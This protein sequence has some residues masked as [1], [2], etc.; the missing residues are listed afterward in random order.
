MFSRT[1]IPETTESFKTAG[2]DSGDTIRINNVEI[3]PQK[4]LSFQA[5]SGNRCGHARGAPRYYHRPEHHKRRPSV[6]EEAIRAVMEFNFYPKKFLKNVGTLNPK[7]RRKRSERREAIVSVSQVLIHYVELITLKVGFYTSSGAMV[8]LDLDYI[9]EKAGVAVIRAKR[10]INDLVKAGYI[11]LSSQF[12]RKDDG[13]FI[14]LPSI[15]EISL[16]FFSDLGIDLQRLFFL[17]EWKRKQKEKKDSKKAHKKLR[18][19][20]DTAASMASFSGKGRQTNNSCSPI[21]SIF[22]KFSFRGKTDAA[23]ERERQ[24]ISKALA[25]HKECPE[26]SLVDYHK[27]LLRKRE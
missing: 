6:L 16:S 2:V 15:R 20:I 7:N 14:G 12:K 21:A 3:L 8:L 10:A 23:I 4:P 19:I 17:R 9:A 5:E 22:S 1:N 25:L 27:E 13:S 18:G 11:K 26:R 24:I